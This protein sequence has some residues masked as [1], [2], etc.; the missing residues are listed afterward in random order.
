M[1]DLVEPLIGICHHRQPNFDQFF[2]RSS[3]QPTCS[4]GCLLAHDDSPRRASLRRI[5]CRWPPPQA[6]HHGLIRYQASMQN[7]DSIAA[8]QIQRSGKRCPLR[9][10]R[11]RCGYLRR[12]AF[13]S[14]E[15]DLRYR[16]LFGQ[17]PAP[18]RCA[19]RRGG[20]DF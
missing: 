20:F 19:P 14:N 1:R 18:I 8:C 11:R 2:R 7:L 3:M 9:A 4:S 12:W 16:L 17:N 6:K 10:A 13:R 5:V 15:S